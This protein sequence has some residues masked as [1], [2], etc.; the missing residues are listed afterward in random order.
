MA[1]ETALQPERV[2]ILG[3]GRF[4]TSLARNLHD[5]G[6]EVTAID[7]DEKRV[8]DV[9]NFVALAAQGDGTD[10][11]LLRSL[12]IDRSDVAIVAQG[13]SLEGSV[14][15]TLLLKRLEVPWVVAK[16]RTRLHGEILER[17][18]ADRVVYPEAEAG[19]RLAHSLGVRNI[20][21]YISLT[22]TSGVAKVVAPPH[23]IGHTIA[24]LGASQHAQLNLL[25]IKRGRRVIV[26]PHYE[27][28]IQPDDELLL[29][30]PDI[31][32]YKFMHP[33]R[34]LAE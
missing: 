11:E 17:I 1:P 25:M 26:M 21:D 22:E 9:A 16:A 12:H 20:N 28:R 31:E 33:G 30:G 4:G 2:T 24:E 14:L 7:I 10:E 34:E 15:A 32:I 19:A 5:L 8:A 18:G 27:E 3:L 13:A 6:Y 29:V 23:F